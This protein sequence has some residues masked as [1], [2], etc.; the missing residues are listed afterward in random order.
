MLNCV[1]VSDRNIFKA[2]FAHRLREGKTSKENY[3]TSSFVYVLRHNADAAVAIAARFLGTPVEELR[4]VSEVETQ[5]AFRTETPNP[6]TVYPDITIRGQ[7]KTGKRFLI[8]VENKWDSNANTEQLRTYRQL[9]QGSRLVFISPSAA[10]NALARPCCDS[11]FRWDEV[12]AAL[13]PFGDTD[14]NVASFLEFLNEQSLGPQ[15]PLSLDQIAAYVHAA[16]VPQCCYALAS[17]IAS[18]RWTWDFLPAGLGAVENRH[19]QTLRWGRVGIE[20]FFEHWR[21]AIF[22]GFLLDGKIDHKLDL[23][24]PRKGIDLILLIEADPPSTRVSGGAIRLA[25]QRV[26]TV[27]NTVA[28]DQDQVKSRWRKLVVQT[29]LADVIVAKNT[30]EQQTRAI[31]ERFTE[32]GHALFEDGT[33]ESA[34]RDT[35]PKDAP[36]NAAPTSD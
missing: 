9:E 12:F 27:P 4:N 33:L 19:P 30:E 17:H 24:D 1:A 3:L 26:L 23:V 6:G 14:Q 35:W 25:A 16:R 10:E 31:Y 34:F 29:P 36:W 20:F 11:V 2:L 13:T 15:E 21:P 7:Y 22:A 18:E 28:L 32:W 5:S 8:I